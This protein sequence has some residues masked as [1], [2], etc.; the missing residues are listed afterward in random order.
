V[1]KSLGMINFSKFVTVLFSN[2]N[3]LL[4]NLS[5][6]AGLSGFGDVLI[7]H[8]ERTSANS[9][10]RWNLNRTC[11]MG[12]SFGLTS[13]FFCHYWYN[14]LD[15]KIPGKSIGIVARKIIYD[16]VLFSP[17]LIVA[18]LAVAGIIEASSKQ[19]II[20]DIKEKGT[21][22]YLAE[23]FIWPPAQFFNF[24]FLPTRFRVVYDNVI[25]LGYDM[26][27]SHVKHDCGGDKKGST[28]S[29]Q[30]GQEQSSTTT[31]PPENNAHK[32]SPSSEN[33]TAN[34]FESYLVSVKNSKPIW[35]LNLNF[36]T[37]EW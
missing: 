2:K 19:D 20:K 26:Y 25:S 6:S 15:K 36:D 22:L 17:F 32:V 10:H 3:L 14:F 31:P 35:S 18:C 11:H 7:Q 16:Q 30:P 5:V 12:V 24:Y 23:W 27:T 34:N 4:T 13:G 8:H 28:S 9:A 37:G 29:Q 33:E 21:R 1:P